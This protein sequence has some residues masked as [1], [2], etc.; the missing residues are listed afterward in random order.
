MIFHLDLIVSSAREIGR[1]I[2]AVWV[3]LSQ[4]KRVE[5]TARVIIWHILRRDFFVG[6]KE[7]LDCFVGLLCEAI[8]LTELAFLRYLLSSFLLM[9]RYLLQL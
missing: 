5:I 7:S 8:I 1:S 4:I 9:L 6:A 3:L 2:L